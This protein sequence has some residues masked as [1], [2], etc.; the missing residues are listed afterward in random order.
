M[1]PAK[2]AEILE[3]HN[4]WRRGDDAHP[5][6]SPTLIGKAIDVAVKVLREARK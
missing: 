3:K 2:A 4:A 1:T 6:Q 5:M